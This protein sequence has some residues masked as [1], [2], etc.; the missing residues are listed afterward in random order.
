[1][2]YWLLFNYLTLIIFKSDLGRLF[3]PTLSFFLGSVCNI[4]VAAF[5]HSDAFSSTCHRQKGAA[6]RG[7]LNR[8]SFNNY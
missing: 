3:R 1:M 2:L 4:I 8:T 5:V 7:S 6:P